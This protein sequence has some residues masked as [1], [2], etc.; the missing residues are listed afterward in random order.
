MGVNLVAG[1]VVPAQAY[2]C[3]VCCGIGAPRVC[4]VMLNQ[5]FEMQ[6]RDDVLG[7]QT[8]KWAA[9]Q[10]VNRFMR[11][12]FRAASRNVNA[13]QLAAAMPTVHS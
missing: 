8:E 2:A 11:A 12:D 9:Q 4:G 13:T 1:A 5:V 7:S 10:E 6:A 3:S